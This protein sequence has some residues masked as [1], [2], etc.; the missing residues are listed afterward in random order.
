MR[1]TADIQFATHVIDDMLHRIHGGC[2]LRRLDQIHKYFLLHHVRIH[3]DAPGLGGA[4]VALN[5][6]HTLLLVQIQI[7][8]A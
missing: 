7:I 8:T 1:H 4:V 6:L 3:E 5:G 2:L